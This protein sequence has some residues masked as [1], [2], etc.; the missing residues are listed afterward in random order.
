MTFNVPDPLYHNW[1]CYAF[2]FKTGDIDR[3][4]GYV[5]FAS[6]EDRNRIEDVSSPISLKKGE[7]YSLDIFNTGD[8][9]NLTSFQLAYKYNKSLIKILKLESGDL[10]DEWEDDFNILG[11]EIRAVWNSSEKDGINVKPESKILRIKFIALEDMESS[12]SLFAITK[13]SENSIP[14]LFYSSNGESLPVSLN[15]NLTHL[16]MAPHIT[17]YP[18]P[19]NDRVNLRFFGEPSESKFEILSTEGKVVQSGTVNTSDLMQE[20]SIEISDDVP[21]GAYFLKV[22]SEDKVSTVSLIRQ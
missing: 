13:S 6:I 7:I 18:N 11:D 9:N 21:A 14:S 10:T 1:G 17:I 8:I 5:S 19:V 2:G 12:T 20:V 3:S 15:S 22:I 4:N 16:S